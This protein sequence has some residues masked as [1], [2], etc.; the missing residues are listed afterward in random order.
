[1][2]LKN[3][4]CG[5]HYSIS[6]NLYKL[7]STFMYGTGLLYGVRLYTF[8]PENKELPVLRTVHWGDNEVGRISKAIS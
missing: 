4:F 2:K 1:M 6:G 5:E 8:E 7:V 3:L